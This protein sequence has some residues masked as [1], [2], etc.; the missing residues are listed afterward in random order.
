MPLV[1]P[2]TACYSI[3]CGHPER[4]GF[5]GDDL[6]Q[7]VVNF[8][9]GRGVPESHSLKVEADRG[10]VII[11]GSLPSPNAKWLCLGHV[12]G[13]I[14]LVDEVSVEPLVTSVVRAASGKRL[15]RHRSQRRV[16]SGN[17][18]TVKSRHGEDPERSG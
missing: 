1:R 7:R 4:N 17:A 16:N 11:R 9:R 8:L 14:T 18:E 12:A 15:E 6:Q 5:V 10:T 13:V 2:T 3:E